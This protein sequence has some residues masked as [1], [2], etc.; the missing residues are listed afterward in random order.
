MIKTKELAKNSIEDRNT[1]HHNITEAN[2]NSNEKHSS[3]TSSKNVKAVW[4]CRDCAKDYDVPTGS[5]FFFLFLFLLNN[6]FMYIISLTKN[7][8]S[9][10]FIPTSTQVNH[11]MHVMP[12]GL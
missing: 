8:Y 10:I 2:G 11:V 4:L 1:I 12:H 7:K 3:K 9:H 6:I 5:P